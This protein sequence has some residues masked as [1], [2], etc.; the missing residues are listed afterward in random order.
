MAVA[1][2]ASQIA[3]MVSRVPQPPTPTQQQQQQPNNIRPYGIVV[4]H[5][6]NNQLTI[7]QQRMAIVVKQEVIGE[8]TTPTST[9]ASTVVKMESDE[10]EHLM[11]SVVLT[12]ETA[13]EAPR[14]VPTTVAPSTA[15]AAAAAASDEIR[16]MKRR[17]YQQKRRQSVANKEL[18]AGVQNQPVNNVMGTVPSAVSVIPTVTMNV[19]SGGSGGGSGG[20]SSGAT[21]PTSGV[22]FAPAKKRSRKGSKYE[23]L[24]Y[25]AFIEA[26]MTQIRTALPPLTVQ[27]PQLG[28]G[29]L[30]TASAVFGAGD[31]TPF[32]SRIGQNNNNNLY[33]AAAVVK[34]DRNG[35][36][37]GSYGSA[38]LPGVSDY[39]NTRP[40]GDAEPVAPTPPVPAPVAPPTGGSSN[41]QRG[42]Y[43]QEFAWPRWDPRHQ[44][45]DHQSRSRSSSSCSMLLDSRGDGC[46]TPDTVVSSSSPECVLP[47]PVVRFPGLRFIDLAEERNSSPEQRSSCNSPDIPILA[48]VPIRPNAI[49]VASN[50]PAAAVTPSAGVVAIKKEA[51]LDTENLPAGSCSLAREQQQQPSPLKSQ[52]GLGAPQPL[53]DSTNVT[54]TLTLNA[55]AAEDVNQV[56]CRLAALLRVPPPTGYQ[57]VERT[58]APASQRLGLYR[59]KGKDGKE[60]TPVDIQSILNGTTKFCRHCDVVILGNDKMRSCSPTSSATWTRRGRRR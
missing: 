6:V 60:G 21:T 2:P 45:D 37:K 12:S 33:S 23:E 8:P 41:S 13:Q 27:E 52:F 19:Q 49:T 57:I 34:V 26:I 54:V 7:N 43:H 42:F 59:F 46:D 3:Q 40:F 5:P 9:T 36:L 24:D 38:C 20:L 51:S 56:L 17:Q 22:P 47:E 18:S 55:S 53:R 11:D 32:A 39:Y 35:S 10:N 14:S 28:R 58:S 30:S 25:D 15:A 4:R 48:P 44:H 50:P 16:K 1:L 29:C 31:L